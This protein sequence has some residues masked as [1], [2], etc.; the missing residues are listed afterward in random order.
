MNDLSRPRFHI[1]TTV[2]R[3]QLYAGPHLEDLTAVYLVHLEKQMNLE[4]IP[5]CCIVQSSPKE[6]VSLRKWCAEV[7]G[8]AT[9]QAFFGSSLLELAPTLLKDFY[10]FDANSWKLMYGY[11]R[12][13]AKV[14]YHAKD[15]NTEAFIR[16]FELPAEERR[17]ACHYM[18]ALEVN[19]RK[20]GMTNR[21]IALAAQ[22]FFWA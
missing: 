5:A 16:Y 20:A 4:N 7:I 18:R 14:M 1:G 10:T 15:R 13:F 22:M 9:I 3:E 17:D 6:V 2:R 11:P 21:D 12:A 8:K 19:Q